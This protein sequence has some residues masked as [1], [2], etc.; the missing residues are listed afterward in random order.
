MVKILAIGVVCA[1]QRPAAPLGISTDSARPVRDAFRFGSAPSAIGARGADTLQSADEGGQEVGDALGGTVFAG[2]TLHLRPRYIWALTCTFT[3]SQHSRPC[4][5]GRADGRHAG[6]AAPKCRG[7][8][9]SPLSRRHGAAMARTRHSVGGRA[10]AAAVPSTG[11]KWVQL[12]LGGIGLRPRPSTRVSA[13]SS[14]RSPFGSR[15][16]IRVGSARLRRRYQPTR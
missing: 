10:P 16:N 15:P 3:S 12:S 6:W 2:R 9:G 13:V 8:Q 14:T 1:G 5:R 11:T 4:G 7:T